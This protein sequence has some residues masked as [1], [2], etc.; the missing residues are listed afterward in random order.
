MNAAT[1]KWSKGIGY[2]IMAFI[3]FSAVFARDGLGLAG[4]DT[5]L[6]T[7]S[8][9][10]SGLVNGLNI[11]GILGALIMGLV[12]WV[13]TFPDTPNYVYQG[14]DELVKKNGVT[15]T[16]KSIAF[17]KNQ[18]LFINVPYW[19]LLVM[20]GWL[21][22]VVVWVTLNGIIQIWNKM[23][24]DYLKET[25]GDGNE[26]TTVSSNLDTNPLG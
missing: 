26:K 22:T 5:A 25:Y 1:A 13:S 14:V 4:D 19:L 3:S 17:K 15:D 11:L 20:S 8:A 2:L 18:F 16:A 24:R 9:M 10:G 12:Y 6:L 21:F 23:Q 7:L